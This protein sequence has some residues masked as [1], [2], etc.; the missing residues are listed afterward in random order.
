MIYSCFEKSRSRSVT[1]PSQGITS[2]TS[3]QVSPPVQATPSPM[4]RLQSGHAQQMLQQLIAEAD[5]NHVA[6]SE[7][8]SNNE[9]RDRTLLGVK[10]STTDDV[11]HKKWLIELVNSQVLLKGCETQGYVILSAAKSQV[12]QRIHRLDHYL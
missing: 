9:P 7:D 11:L 5:N 1:D 10:A 3:I 12:L 8:C 6:F 4:S 2:P